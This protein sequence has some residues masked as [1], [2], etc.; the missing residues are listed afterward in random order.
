[1]VK[2]SVQAAAVAEAVSRFDGAL[3]GIFGT[4][5]IGEEP[6]VVPGGHQ[7]GVLESGADGAAWGSHVSDV[8]GHGHGGAAGISGWEWDSARTEPSGELAEVPGHAVENIV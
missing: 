2:D 4:H 7:A 5:R 8:A 1:M 6:G 3:Q